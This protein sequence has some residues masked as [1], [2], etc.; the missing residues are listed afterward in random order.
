MPDTARPTCDYSVL[1]SRWER[2]PRAGFWPI[3]IRDRLPEVPIPL[4]RHDGDARVDLQAALDHVHD[5]S[6]YANFIYRGSPT[7]PLRPE[8]MEWARQFLPVPSA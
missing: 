1:V 3:G 5:A 6:G 2:R 4:R 7:P 8:D